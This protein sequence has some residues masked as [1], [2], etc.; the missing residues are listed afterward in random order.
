MSCIFISDGSFYTVI[1]HIVGWGRRQCINVSTH[2]LGLTDLVS[3]CYIMKPILD[4]LVL[5]SVDRLAIGQY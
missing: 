1:E 5:C 3:A 4:P 2:Q